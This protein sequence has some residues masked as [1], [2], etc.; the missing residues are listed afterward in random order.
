MN[1]NANTATPTTAKKSFSTAA[2]A[3]SPV[4]VA[5]GM[6]AIQR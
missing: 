6:T 1:R 4:T 5:V 3:R 2:A